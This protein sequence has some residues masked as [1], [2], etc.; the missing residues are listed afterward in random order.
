MADFRSD[1]THGASPEILEA[2]ARANT[3]TVVSYGTDPFTAR[4]EERCRE[5]FE[6]DLKVFPVLTGTAGNSLSI[7]SMTP[8]WGAVFCHEQ[9]HIHRDEMGAPE[10]FSGG[11]KVFPVAGAHGKLTPEALTATMSAPHLSKGVH[12]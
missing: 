6:H 3:G 10:F 1:N 8:P 9:A 7:A 2:V 12:R 5:L 11:A 4:V